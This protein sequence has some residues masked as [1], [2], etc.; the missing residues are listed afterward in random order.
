MEAYIDK[1][2][3]EDSNLTSFDSEDSSGNSNFQIS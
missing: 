2:G 1:L 3:D